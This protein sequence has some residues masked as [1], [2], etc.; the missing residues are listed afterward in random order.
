MKHLLALL[1]LA[2]AVHANT[3]LSIGQC[4]V[5]ELMNGTNETVCASIPS[6]GINLTLN[7]SD[8][9]ASSYLNSTFNISIKAIGNVSVVVQ[10][11]TTII[12]VTNMSCPAANLTLYANST[13]T[14][15][16]VSFTCLQNTS[17]N[18]CNFNA[19]IQP[20]TSPQY[21]RNVSGLNITANPIPAD[22][23][24]E[25]RY[26]Q[27]NTSFIWRSDKSNST[28]ICQPQQGVL[29][30]PPAAPAPVCPPAVVCDAPID[31]SEAVRI[32]I[33]GIN[34]SLYGPG[35]CVEQLKTKDGTLAQYQNLSGSVQ[36]EVKTQ[37]DPWNQSMTIILLIVIAGA[38]LWIWKSRNGPDPYKGPPAVT[39]D[40]IAEIKRKVKQ[41]EGDTSGTG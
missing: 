36:A 16:N 17:E 2:A 25:N 23:C 20:S 8:P 29:S 32:S 22:Y 4:Q 38:G 21:F 19:V 7:A 41:M 40:R 26:E 33:Q 1:L 9:N 37:T 35:G 14:L 30:C 10:N 28:Y 34:T 3:N 39:K 15:N 6:L 31:C 27:S 13:Q 24:F 18:Y 12:N 5:F 11:L